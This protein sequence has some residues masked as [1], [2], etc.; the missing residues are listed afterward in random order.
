MILAKVTK[1]LYKKP[2]N[3]SGII[4]INAASTL[5]TGLFLST[6]EILY[7][8][9]LFTQT[10]FSKKIAYKT[11]IYLVII[12]IFLLVFTLISNLVKFQIKSLGEKDLRERD[13]KV[14]LF[15][16]LKNS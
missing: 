9:K 1:R 2:Y 10:C 12:F 16:V 3:F 8:N 6:I 13:K 11:T 5:V 7:L 14:E 4:F 15:T